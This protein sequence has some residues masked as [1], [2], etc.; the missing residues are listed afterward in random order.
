MYPSPFQ[1]FSLSPPISPCLSL[2]LTAVLL[3][4]LSLPYHRSA[5]CAA[6][7]PKWDKL[8][9]ETGKSV[10]FYDVEADEFKDIAA[11]A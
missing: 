6:I 3:P 10:H 5:P 4:L 2:A 1:F 11:L 8:E 7:K 9:T